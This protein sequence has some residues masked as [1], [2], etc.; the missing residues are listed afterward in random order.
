MLVI[1]MMRGVMIEGMILGVGMIQDLVPL[2]TVLM[3]EGVVMGEDSMG[4]EGLMVVVRG[5]EEEILEEVVEGVR[6]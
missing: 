1:M 3:I 5:V 2:P 6:V 4:V